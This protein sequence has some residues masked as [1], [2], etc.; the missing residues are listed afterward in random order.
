MSVESCL[1]KSWHMEIM[2]KCSATVK[3]IKEWGSSI[4]LIC[5]DLQDAFLNEGG[6]L[7]V[8]IVCYICFKSG[9]RNVLAFA[10]I[11]IFKYLEIYTRN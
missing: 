2:R 8:C 7:K 4:V 9:E 11:Y 10:Y 3:N 1:N 6:K 5:K